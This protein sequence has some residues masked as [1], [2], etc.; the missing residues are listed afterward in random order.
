M[1]TGRKQPDGGTIGSRKIFWRLKH[2]PAWHRRE[3]ASRSLAARRKNAI[4]HK[5]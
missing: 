1:L 2:L 5:P 3:R 4:D